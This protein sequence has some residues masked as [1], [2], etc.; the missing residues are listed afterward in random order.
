[1]TPPLVLTI[2]QDYPT[3]TPYPLL[4]PLVGFAD[5][6]NLTVAHTGQELHTPDDGPTVTQQANDLL[7]VTI[8]YLSHSNL[9]VHP[10]KSVAMIKGSAT[11][12]SLGPR[13]PPM[14][15]VEATTQLRVIQTTNPDDT[16]FP[17][18]L[19]SHVAHL[20][21]YVSPAT[22]A[23]SLSHKHLPFEACI[24]A[25]M[26]LKGASIGLKNLDALGMVQR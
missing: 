7:D 22:K 5:D 12:H 20:P 11:A 23:L 14:H 4:S 8:S 25:K 17:Q 3:P 6:T 19:Q 13:G 24:F 1:M 15:V 9:I 21:P 10:T 2:E 16:S 26:V 18:K